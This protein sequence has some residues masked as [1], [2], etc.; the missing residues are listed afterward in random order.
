MKKRPFVFLAAGAGLLFLLGLVAAAIV[1]MRL[2]DLKDR[3]AE[4]IGQALGARVQVSS[5]TLDVSRGEVHAG[6][7]TLANLRPEAPWDRG[8]IGQATLRFHWRDFFSPVQP[9]AVEVSDWRLVLRPGATPGGET[10]APAEIPPPGA[11]GPAHHGIA[12]TSLH[13]EEGEVEIDLQGGRQVQ[14]HGVSLDAADN[15]GGTWNTRLTVTALEAGTLRAEAGAVEIRSDAGKITFTNLRLQCGAGFMTGE[16]EIALQG[17]HDRRASLLATDVPVTMLVA[18]P[19]QMKVSGLIQ[20]HLDYQGDDTAAEAHGSLILAH[21]KVNVLP[22]LGQV[23][24]MVGLPNIANMELDHATTNFDWK[25]G[26][27]HLKQIDL[28]KEGIIR[29]AGDTDI[30]PTGQVDGRLK[31]GLP[32]TVISKWPQLQTAVFSSTSDDTSWTDVHVTGTPDHL[33]EDLSGRL[34]TTGIQSGSSL[35]QQGAQGASSLLKSFL[36]P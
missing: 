31:L 23:A 32:N 26:A 10:S 2:Q 7:I 6:G 36:G 21:G 29:V 18:M 25:D 15:G 9:L 13:A 27:L 8:E 33:Q 1:W 19:W 35:L 4:N 12:V 24:A 34:L 30:D 14:I 22:L 3:L 28:R 20:G 11:P 17:A 16:G 5:L